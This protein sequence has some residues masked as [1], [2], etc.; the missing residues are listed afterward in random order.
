MLSIGRVIKQIII[1]GTE[2]AGRTCLCLCVGQCESSTQTQRK[3]QSVCVCVCVCV[4]IWRYL[5]ADRG[6]V[7]GRLEN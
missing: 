5:G 4:C 1:Q 3:T 2:E 7:G 6:Q